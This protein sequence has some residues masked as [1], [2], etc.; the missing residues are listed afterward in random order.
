MDTV[1]NR[2]LEAVGRISEGLYAR[3]DVKDVIR[4]TISTALELVQ[5]E[6]GA[7]LLA[8]ADR[9]QLVCFDAV[10]SVASSVI[11][12]SIPWNHGLVGSVFSSGE[13]EIV[14]DV[15]G[16]LRHLSILDATTDYIPRQLIV[17]PL[18]RW[19]GEPLG[20]LQILNKKENVFTKEDADILAIVSALATAVIEQMRT[21]ETLRHSEAQLR[22]AQKMEVIGSLAGGIAH[23]FNNLVTVIMGYSEM[24]LS[25]AFDEGRW[26]RDLAQIREAGQR[27]AGLTRQLL[28]FSRRQVLLPTIVEVNEAILCMADMLQ[29]LVGE[30]I[31]VVANL[32]SCPRTIEIDR[33]QLEQ[34]IMNLAVNARDAMEHGGRLEFQTEHTYVS[35]VNR[36]PL[37][38]GHYVMITVR[39]TGC[40]IDPL[41]QSRIFEPFFTTKPIGKG[42]GL[43]LSTVYGIIKQ[44]G[45]TIT[46]R[47]E[48][49]KGTLFTIYLPAS[50]RQAE[51]LPDSSKPPS[52]VSGTILLVE[53][54]PAVRT[55]V[56]QLL[57]GSG[58][59]VIEA[60]HGFEALQKMQ[61]LFDQPDLILTDVVMPQMSGI[62]LV[63]QVRQRH[64]K[65]KVLYMSGYSDHH[66]LKDDVLTGT[67]FLQK[68]F[69]PVGLTD[70]VRQAIQPIESR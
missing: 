36:L 3:T 45:G 48:V 17:V 47:S 62:D 13:G 42:T 34:I 67:A 1:A 59:H 23:D 33:S 21:M 25:A 56:A 7:V 50:C 64:A 35:E 20:V 43:G 10:G 68:P 65:T 53:D 32:D 27:A 16:D 46:I 9:Q 6:A 2:Y 28:A 31:Q 58:Y 66:A 55:L 14:T 22:E 18:K 12:A 29:Q 49:G 69:T 61:T 57:R 51:L 52:T 19:Q 37:S 26:R 54:E 40:G 11:G 41:I 30:D 15:T 39:D 8:N 63:Q 24:L 70:A 4:F 60:T 38:P 5:A 44:S